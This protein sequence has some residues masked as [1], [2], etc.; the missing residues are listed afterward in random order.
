[1]G[2]KGVSKRKPQQTKSKP[3]SD[4]ETGS[5]SSVVQEAKSQSTKSFKI[6]K[7]DSSKSS[8]GNKKKAKKD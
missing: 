6:G 7:G 1:M 2:R 8:T 3:L 4:K 5:V